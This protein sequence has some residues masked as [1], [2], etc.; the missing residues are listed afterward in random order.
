MNRREY[1]PITVHRV[2][3]YITL[4]VEVSFDT[5]YA[6][7][8]DIEANAYELVAEGQYDRMDTDLEAYDILDSWEDYD[9]VG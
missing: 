5:E 9:E 7:A 1:H 3:A 6:N 2:K 8:Q 4:K